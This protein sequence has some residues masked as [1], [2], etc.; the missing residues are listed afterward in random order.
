MASA[1]AP[2][3]GALC[4]AQAVAGFGLGGTMVPF[5]LLAELTPPSVRG[6]VLNGSNW[7]WSVGTVGVL[8]RNG[9]QLEAYNDLSG[10]RWGNVR[11]GAQRAPM[12][13]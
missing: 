12:R 4:A 13:E 3:F 9:A 2:T 1:L 6:V 10:M 7:C 11:Q 5:D 8:L